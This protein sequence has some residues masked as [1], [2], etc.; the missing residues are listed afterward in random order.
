MT[1][2]G[3]VCVRGEVVGD[4]FKVYEQV[5][6]AGQGELYS[7]FED[8]T[9]RK[10]AVKLQLPRAFEETSEYGLDARDMK[11][12]AVRGVRLA[13]PGIPEIYWHGPYDNRYCIVME[14]L[15]GPTLAEAL[16]R[17][18]PV[19]TPTVA[20][21]VGRLCEILG[22]VHG[23][24]LVHRD[25]KPSNVMLESPR[26]RVKLLDLGYAERA[27]RLPYRTAGTVGWMAPEQFDARVVV[28]PASDIFALGCLI[29]DMTVMTLPYGAG[30]G[31]PERSAPV[32]PAD[33]LAA[34]PGDLRDLALAMVSWAP[35][36]RPG[37][38][39]EVLDALAPVLPTP[40]SPPPA[41]P[42]DPDPTTGYRLAGRS[43]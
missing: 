24:G 15:E 27:G 10:V 7:A 11:D 35:G 9:G 19:K 16:A 20:A 26:G 41:R 25:V 42:L 5:T 4:R 13:G 34:L 1:L 38:A 33:R 43:C 40:G 21:V 12:E 37:S 31:R 22:R 30:P 14:Y 2:L 36:D 8:G 32:L 28:T 6:T 17:R 3:V 23:E 18:R 29:L 39:K